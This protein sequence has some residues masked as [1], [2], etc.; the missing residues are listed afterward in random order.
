MRIER[1]EVF[2]NADLGLG[3]MDFGMTNADCGIMVKVRMCKSVKERRG[4]GKRKK[5]RGKRR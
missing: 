2:G 5:K 3:N 4:K 1:G